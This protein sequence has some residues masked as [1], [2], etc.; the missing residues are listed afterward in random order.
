[1]SQIWIFLSQFSYNMLHASY[2]EECKTCLSHGPMYDIIYV[3][4]IFSPTEKH[5][6]FNWL[7]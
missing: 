1:M 3:F 5:V 7:N 4:I 6:I 2:F